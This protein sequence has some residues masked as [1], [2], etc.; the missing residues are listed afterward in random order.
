MQPKN[1]LRAKLKN[2]ANTE[3]NKG[4]RPAAAAPKVSSAQLRKQQNA[5][6]RRILEARQREMARMQKAQE[7]FMAAARALRTAVESTRAVP[8]PPVPVN[9]GPL[10][11]VRTM[12]NFTS[13]LN[14][15]S[16]A[17]KEKRAAKAAAKLRGKNSNSSNNE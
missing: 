2:R 6:K 16:R 3:K 1:V 5:E 14:K 7:E 8:P 4:A 10:G 11:P 15:A 13:F 12:A 9:A 17:A